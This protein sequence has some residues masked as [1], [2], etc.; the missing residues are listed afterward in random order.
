[1]KASSLKARALRAAEICRERGITQTEIA[2]AL[3]ASQGQVSRILRG[4]NLR[5]SRLF[6]EVCLYAERFGQGV[7][8]KAV[9]ENQELIEALRETWDGSAVHSH[10]LAT[11]IRS[12]AALGNPVHSPITRKE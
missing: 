1:M 7:T 5:A 12:L 2:Q 6:E 3:G 11:V 4:H 10:A 8:A 9:R